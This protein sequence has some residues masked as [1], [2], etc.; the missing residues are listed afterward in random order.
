MSLAPRARRA[1]KERFRR[2]AKNAAALAHP[3]IVEISDYGETDDGTPYLV[4]EL[5]EGSSLDAIWWSAARCPRR[6]SRPSAHRSREGL[7]RAH[8]FQVIHRDLKPENVFVARG[9]R[10]AA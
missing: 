8:D 2:E 5:L 9:P 10:A 1:L 3:N 7:A 6:R 4:M